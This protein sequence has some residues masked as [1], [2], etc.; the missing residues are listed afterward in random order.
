MKQ[1]WPLHS[2]S[3]N[4]APMVGLVSAAGLIGLLDEPNDEIKCY[5]L[6]QLD[7][8]VNQLW[9]EVADHISKLWVDYFS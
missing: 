7:S 8:L 3:S 2:S 6:K 4:T 9:A 5:A 1:T